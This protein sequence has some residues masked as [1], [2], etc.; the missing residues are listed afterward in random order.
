[1]LTV[2]K[3]DLRLEARATVISMI[4]EVKLSS[5]A[6]TATLALTVMAIA[7]SA[8]VDSAS[9]TTIKA[10]S[11]RIFRVGME[12][13]YERFH[14]RFRLCGAGNSWV[15]HFQERATSSKGYYSGTRRYTFDPAYGSKSNYCRTVVVGGDIESDFSFS[16]L[17]VSLRAKT[18]RGRWSRLIAARGSTSYPAGA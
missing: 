18:S 13:G 2:S 15:V 17:T 16:H 8:G 7:L 10:P 12:Y 14:V 3:E 6:S 4:T 5:I 1:M 9:A 11:M